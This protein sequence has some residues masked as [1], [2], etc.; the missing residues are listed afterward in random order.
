M[1]PV[2]EVR[3][4]PTLFWLPKDGKNKPQQYQGG[5]EL[6]D[7]VKYDRLSTEPSSHIWGRISL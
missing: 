7:L 6:S 4:F 2:L 5:G 1:P 3:G